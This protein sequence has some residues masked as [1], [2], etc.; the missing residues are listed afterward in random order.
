MGTAKVNYKD[1]E[2]FQKRVRESLSGQQFDLFIESCAKA[3]AA[4]LIAIVVEKTPV[5]DYSGDPYTCLVK[6]FAHKG[7]KVAGKVGG[8]LRR[9]WTG[10][11]SQAASSYAGNL[12]VHRFGDTYV[13]EV[14]NTVEYASYVEFGHRTR[15]GGG[16]GW[17]EGHFMLKE[18]EILLRQKAP[19]ALEKKLNRKLREVFK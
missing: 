10:G 11:T 8:T 9:G 13:I 5:G 17:V 4:E 1:L 7:N 19:R 16:Q 14:T 18:S 6:N 2:N 15:N 3:L 12:K